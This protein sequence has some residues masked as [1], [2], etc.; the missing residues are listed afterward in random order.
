[1]SN[2]QKCPK[3]HRPMNIGNSPNS[4][5][6][7]ET[8]DEEGVCE[9]YAAL[10]EERE[11]VDRIWKDKRKIEDICYKLNQQ[12]AAEQERS[13][14]W[15]GR[16][17]QATSDSYETFQQLLQAQAAIA[18]HNTRHSPSGRMIVDLSA[19]DKHDAELNKKF[20]DRHTRKVIELRLR[21]VKPLV[22]ALQAIRDNSRYD[23][24]HLASIA[25]DALAKVKDGK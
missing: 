13:D 8:D 19:L 15:K 6:C 21:E 16:Y 2:E 18:E 11:N 23:G 4:E 14:E 12:L 3:C 9:A 24:S 25:R 5:E 20:S 22:D 1:M 17:E 7:T 10:A